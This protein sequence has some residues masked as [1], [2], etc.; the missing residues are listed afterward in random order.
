MGYTIRVEYTTG[1]SFN[2]YKET[3][4]LEGDWKNLDVLEEN[5]QRIKNH[6]KKYRDFD[7]HNGKNWVKNMPIGC[8]YNGRKGYLDQYKMLLEL[9]TDDRK[10]YTI[11][12]FW[13]GYFEHL[14]SAEI[15]SSKSMRIEF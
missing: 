10:T 1:D 4:D 15:V 11:M 9:L 3:Q 7:Y 5:L 14:H 13:C 2:S 6:Y 8:V 12:P